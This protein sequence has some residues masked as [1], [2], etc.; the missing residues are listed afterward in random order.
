MYLESDAEGENTLCEPVQTLMQL[1]Q[2]PSYIGHVKPFSRALS[3]E[4][5]SSIRNPHNFWVVSE[6]QFFPPLHI[7]G[8]A[9]AKPWMGPGGDHW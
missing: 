9:L 8:F 1:R 7:H 4:I 3:T 5:F 6:Y 2:G